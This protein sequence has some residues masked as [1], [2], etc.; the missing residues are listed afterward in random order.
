MGRLWEADTT[1]S[2]EKKDQAT[3]FGFLD[4]RVDDVFAPAVFLFLS[5][6]PTTLFFEPTYPLASRSLSSH[7]HPKTKPQI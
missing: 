3:F 2:K 6:P 4:A 1:D 5:L 7:R